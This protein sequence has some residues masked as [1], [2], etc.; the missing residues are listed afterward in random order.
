[1]FLDLPTVKVWN[2]LDDYGV[3]SGDKYPAKYGGKPQ[4]ERS[5]LMLTNPVRTN[6]LVFL[7]TLYIP[8]T[9]ILARL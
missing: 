6:R 5:N 9:N 7:I 3:D 2:M 8:E 1:M 4:H